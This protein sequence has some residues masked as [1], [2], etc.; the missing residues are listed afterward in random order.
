VQDGQQEVRGGR[1]RQQRPNLVEY[2]HGRAVLAQIEVGAGLHLVKARSYVDL[3]ILRERKAALGHAKNLLVAAPQ[4]EHLSEPDE[5]QAL[6]QAIARL[7]AALENGLIESLRLVPLSEHLAGVRKRDRERRVR[8]QDLRRQVAQV[9]QESGRTPLLQHPRSQ[10]AQKH[11]GIRVAPRREVVPECTL[12]LAARRQ[13]GGRVGLERPPGLGASDR[14]D[15]LAD[16]ATHQVVTFV[17]RLR[18]GAERAQQTASSEGFEK[19]VVSVATRQHPRQVGVE[20]GQRGGP[21]QHPSRAGIETR[22]DLG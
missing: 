6:V 8:V 7:A 3:Q 22:V 18:A 16:E 9:L 5:G 19:G 15:L 17:R 14:L 1:R 21:L 20:T 4:V 11:G 13:R 10:V 12:R 2:A